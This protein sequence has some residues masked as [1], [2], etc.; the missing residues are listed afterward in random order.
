[1]GPLLEE[2][3]PLL[4]LVQLPGTDMQVSVLEV[5]LDMVLEDT[6]DLLPALPVLFP[7]PMALLS[8]LTTTP[9]DSDMLV[10]MVM[11]H[12]EL[13]LLVTLMVLLYQLKVPTL[14]LPEKLPW[15]LLQLEVMVV[16]QTPTTSL[17]VLMD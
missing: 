11:V 4:L 13:L 15:L 5:L 7:T 16:A 17:L 2:L 6:L 8:Q 14:L 3:L 12:M 9:W 1:M 10:H